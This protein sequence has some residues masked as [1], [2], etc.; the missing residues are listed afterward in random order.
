[1]CV[2]LTV[3]QGR[4][5]LD[6]VYSSSSRLL[7]RTASW[8]GHTGLCLACRCLPLML[9][10]GLAK[11]T[12]HLRHR[13]T[14]PSV[15]RLELPSLHPSWLAVVVSHMLCQG[16]APDKSY[17]MSDWACYVTCLLGRIG[18]PARYVQMQ[19]AVSIGLSPLGMLPIKAWCTS[20]LQQTG[21]GVGTFCKLPL[22]KCVLQG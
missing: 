18:V 22:R 11:T 20:D 9:I 12:D 10:L 8:N 19:S 1:M 21:P 3:S 13:G 2:E 14:T 4:C 6:A 17:R 16:P 7:C 5:L 15:W